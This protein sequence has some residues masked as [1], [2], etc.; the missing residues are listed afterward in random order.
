MP[1]ALVTG[2]SRGLGAV[3]AERLARDGFAVAVNSGRGAAGAEDVVRADPRGRR[4]GGRVRRRRHRR[5]A[6]RAARRR[7]RGAARA[8]RAC[9]CSTRPGRSRAPV[10][11]ARWDDHLDQLDFFVRS[12]VLLGRAVCP[13]CASAA[14]G[15]IVHVDSE[16]ADRPPPGMGGLRDGQERADRRWP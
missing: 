2:S 9:S 14:V 6:G 7:D 13:G 1:V 16:V 12:P 10:D 4:H 3:I 15:R 5:G 8:D 11:D